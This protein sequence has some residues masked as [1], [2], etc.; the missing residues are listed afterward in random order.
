MKVIGNDSQ[1][2]FIYGHA[3]GAVSAGSPVVFNNNTSQVQSI[4][5]T[6]ASA[7]VISGTTFES[8]Q[9]SNICSVFDKESGKLIIAYMDTADTGKG[10]C[11]V[12]TPTA[13]G[14][15]YGPLS[16]FHSSTGTAMYISITMVKD[17]DGV[18][19]KVLVVYKRDTQNHLSYRL[20]TVMS[21]GADTAATVQWGKEDLQVVNSASTAVTSCAF[22]PIHQRVAVLQ[23]TANQHQ[24]AIGSVVGVRVIWYAQ[25]NIHG[26]N[27]YTSAK[28]IFDDHSK[29][30][31]AFTGTSSE[32]RII[33]F[34]I[35]TTDQNDIYHNSPG[36]FSGSAT[37]NIDA[38]HVPNWNR[39][40]F[41]YTDSQ[42]TGYAKTMVT[43]NGTQ[44][45]ST[46]GYT[47]GG[48]SYWDGA[49]LQ[50]YSNSRI[51]YDTHRDKLLVTWTNGQQNDYTY[52]TTGNLTNG[53][54]LTWDA[55]GGSLLEGNVVRQ[56]KD[57][58][59][60]D[61]GD[62]EKSGSFGIASTVGGGPGAA[63]I[64]ESNGTNLTP[65]SSFV[66]FAEGTSSNGEAVRIRSAG[67]I[68]GGLSGLLPGR[69]YYVYKDGTLKLAPEDRDFVVVAGTAIST[70]ELL[71]MG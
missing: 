50:N 6:G 21:A 48:T 22:D 57:V 1:D 27:G 41:I 49:G 45:G 15:V 52:Y 59:Y 13:S 68:V 55:G 18:T 30:F 29:Q 63:H 28:L 47:L 7:N 3:N 14:F 66:G 10:K 40:V 60:M 17:V 54:T 46:A 44:A 64:V 36:T 11:V 34:R 35:K 8:D 25:T 26:S 32:G 61:F 67:S 31:I 37:S 43:I 9:A 5:A 20:G 38:V 62:A 65:H 56:D 4:S 39:N 33:I 58:Q 53:D 71:V 19:S 51:A 70:T 42:G 23:S 12:A 16:L 24:V 2:G 69:K